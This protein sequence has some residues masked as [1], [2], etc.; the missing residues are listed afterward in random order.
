V[1]RCQSLALDVITLSVR[2]AMSTGWFPH[3]RRQWIDFI[4][5]IIVLWLLMM[6]AVHELEVPS[7]ADQWR[8]NLASMESNEATYGL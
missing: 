2:P 5:A 4:I 8:L 7:A 3:T 6:V 1:E